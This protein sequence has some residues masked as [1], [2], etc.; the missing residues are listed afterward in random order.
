[1]SAPLNRVGPPP[2]HI[3]AAEVDGQVSLYDPRT[4]T[5]AVLNSTASDIWRLSSGG[6]VI[7]DLVR[8]LGRAY[9]VDPETIR[10]A[11]HQTV[12]LLVDQGFLVSD[13]S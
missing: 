2:S 5:V 9:Q 3:V 1:V 11:I 7:D 8:A 6:Y 13:A 12:T 10:E 4:E